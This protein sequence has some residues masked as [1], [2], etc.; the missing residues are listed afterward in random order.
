VHFSRAISYAKRLIIGE[1]RT[2]LLFEALIAK[3]TSLGVLKNY[4]EAKEAREE[5]YNLV[6]E[7]YSPDHPMVLEAGNKLIE[8]LLSTEEYYDAERFAR[9][10]YECLTRPVDT[11]SYMVADAS[12]SLATAMFRLNRNDK[13]WDST[14]AEML[15]RKALRIKNIV[16]GPNHVMQMRLL[17]TLADILQVKGY[18]CTHI[19]IYINIYDIQG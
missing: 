5:C 4:K 13:N 15:C 17:A 16:Y 6:A 1:K 19:C 18:I 12:E 3:G 7:F 9:I 2:E 14:E 8:H 11:E 10:S